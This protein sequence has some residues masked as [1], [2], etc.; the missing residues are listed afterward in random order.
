MVNDIRLKLF[1]MFDQ[2]ETGTAEH[3]NEMIKHVY[4]RDD[5]FSFGRSAACKQVICQHD[6]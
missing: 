2:A 5:P 1:I 4:H 6:A 3:R